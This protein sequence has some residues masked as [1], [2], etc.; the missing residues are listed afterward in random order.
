MIAG[1]RQRGTMYG[2]YDLLEDV[3]GCRWY[4]S[5][6]RKI[7]QMKTITIP[8][9]DIEEKPAFGFRDVYY[10]DAWKADFAARNR[11]NGHHMNLDRERGGKVYYRPFVHT[12]RE[13][14]PISK[15]GKSNPEYYS[16]VKGERHPK[17]YETQLCLTNPDVLRIST[18][19]VLRW[20]QEDPKCKL[21]SVS[22]NDL[23]NHCEC[24]ACAAT[25]RELGGQSGLLLKFVNATADEV[26]KEHPEVMIDTLAYWYT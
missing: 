18:E 6:V 9:L 24:D 16:L 12:F 20:I 1:G 5:Q 8:D 26:A 21:I 17:D 25:A 23:D 3:L 14:V 7:P 11:L 15:Y 10:T 4:S 2:V 22:P 13:L 19:T